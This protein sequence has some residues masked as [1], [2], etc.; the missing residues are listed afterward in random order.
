MNNE[1]T[2]Q[3]NNKV[4][5]ITIGRHS[6]SLNYGAALIPFAFQKYLDKLNVE[7]I[8]ID[9]KRNGIGDLRIIYPIIDAIRKRTKIKKII[10]LFLGKIYL[11]IKYN[12]FMDFARKYYRAVDCYGVPFTND[13]FETNKTVDIF[14]FGVIC[15]VSDIIWSNKYNNSFDRTFFCDYEFCKNMIKVAYAP[16]IS[17]GIRFKPEDEDIFRELIQNFDYISVREKQSAEYIQ[18][19][20]K[21]PV[22]YLIDPVLL[23]EK[24]DYYPIIKNNQKYNNYLLVYT[25]KNNKSMLKKAKDLAKLLSLD[26]IEISEFWWNMVCHKRLYSFIGTE[27]FLGYLFNA[28]FVVTDSFHGMCFS[29]VFRKNFYIFPRDGVDLKIKN[30]VTLLDIKEVFVS[31][32]NILEPITIN[33]EKV[34]S[35]LN[36]ERDKSRKFIENTIINSKKT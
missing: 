23:L 25:L 13:Y 34:Y 8:I 27:E 9:Y 18:Q 33:Y 10:R 29:I 17:T 35:I 31:E 28:K 16:S 11:K 12:K 19:F 1:Q 22:P 26:Y 15:C 6:I 20:T 2:I 32:D 24:E 21:K 30:L 14:D 3:K 4:G 36:F 5:I 7:N